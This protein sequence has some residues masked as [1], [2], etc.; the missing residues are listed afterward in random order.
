MYKI[1]EVGGGKDVHTVYEVNGAEET[2]PAIQ[3]CLM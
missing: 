2:D 3:N 1:V